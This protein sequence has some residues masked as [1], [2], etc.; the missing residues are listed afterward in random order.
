MDDYDL[1]NLLKE[2]CVIFI[3]STTG[4]GEEPDN[5]KSFWKL[6]LRKNLPS[7][8]LGFRFAV[9]GLGDSSYVKFNF[10]AKRLNK[11]LAQLGGNM[12]LPLGL[13]DDQ[14][15][16]GFDAVVDPWIDSLYKQLLQ[17]YPLPSGLDPLQ[18]NMIMKPRWH[19]STFLSDNL[20]TNG[21]SPCM[22]HS[23]R[24]LDE[25]IVTVKEITRT[26]DE[27]HFQ[28]VRLI[29]LQ[30]E[31]QSYIPG[32]VVVIRPR[33]SKELVN[34]FQELLKSH[35]IDIPP[36]T[37]FQITSTVDVP[38]PAPLQHHVTFQQLC[39]QYFDLNAVP[40]RYFF[41][42]L[43]NL[44][45]S[46]LEK[47]KLEEFISAEGQNDLYNYCNR[48][49]R[50]IVEVLQ[51]FPHALKNVTED[52]LFEIISP[53]KPR[54]FSIASS[55]KA[56]K[57][58]IHILLAV[59]RYKT[60]LVKERVG[61]CSNYLANLELGDRINVWIKKGSFKFPTDTDA[62]VVLVGPGTGMA[63]FRSFICEREQEGTAKAE[64]IVFFF[65]CR[66]LSDFHCKDDFCRL[67]KEKKIK[68]ICAFSRVTENKVYVQHKIEEN[69]ELLWEL[70]KTENVYIFVAGNSKN[71]P[72]QVRE[73]FVNVCKTNG[74][75]TQKDAD[76][77]I[78]NMEKT[79]KYQT[80]TW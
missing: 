22:Y 30:T 80:E 56:H 44:T 61:L 54:E 77:F 32:D 67:E 64:K 9:L 17:L 42:V 43:L 40:R 3:C 18:V 10:A 24:N 37:I 79:G 35:S 15:D 70:F 33:N 21:P 72:Q 25:F 69:S 27:S 68:L 16:L 11:R 60:K 2:T 29:K 41:N 7:N 31:G 75:M 49:R 74:K 57:D 39:E 14:H 48:P 66:G 12:L 63:P 46:E 13:A 53:I 20:Y 23:T 4:Q 55:Y 59:V 6:L 76:A 52:V 26:T 19:V 65:G 62:S 34:D 50:N 58:E 73:A 47:E 5:M 38:V 28:D 78:E 71:M 36:N 8:L 45:D 1:I 51:D